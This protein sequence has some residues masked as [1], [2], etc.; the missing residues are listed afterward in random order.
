LIE[1]KDLYVAMAED[2]DAKTLLPHGVDEKGIFDAAAKV[3]AAEIEGLRSGGTVAGGSDADLVEEVLCRLLVGGIGL[4]IRAARNEKPLDR[5]PSDDDVIV[6]LRVGGANL[7]A[8]EKGIE[9]LFTSFQLVRRNYLAH[10]GHFLYELMV[11]G[12]PEGEDV[13]PRPA[14][15]A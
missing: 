11:E 6:A 13:E 14:V 3:V 15:D 1:T 8:L 9:G 2:R 7:P 5:E 10:R 4:G 12:A